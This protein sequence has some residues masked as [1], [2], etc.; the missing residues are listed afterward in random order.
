M[1]EEHDSRV[2]SMYEI[3]LA[4][5]RSIIVEFSSLDLSRREQRRY[6]E[7][8]KISQSLMSALSKKNQ[9]WGLTDI[10]R[11]LTHANVGYR[12]VRKKHHKALYS[13]LIIEASCLEAELN[14]EMAHSG[15]V[16]RIS[17]GIR[18]ATRVLLSIF[19]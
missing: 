19:V 8:R 1:R 13:E 4:R 2:K 15:L 14:H 17:S 18:T 12:E 7:M 5:I 9:E 16:K 3:H 11:L 6:E 10:T